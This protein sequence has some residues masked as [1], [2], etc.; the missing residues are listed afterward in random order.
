MPH[1]LNIDVKLK[2]LWQ[3]SKKMEKLDFLDTSEWIPVHTLPGFESC[4]EYFVNR[5]GEVLS[6]KG[7]KE[8]KLKLTVA[9]NGYYQVSLT[10]RLGQKG[11]IKC[12][13][14]KLVAFAFLDTPPTPYGNTK[15]CSLIDH[16]DENK[17]NNNVSN[18]RWVSRSENNNKRPYKRWFGTANPGCKDYKEKNK[19]YN[20]EYQRKRRKDPEFLKKERDYMRCKRAEKK[21]LKIEKSDN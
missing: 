2:V 1:E 6:T 20:R 11:V 18:L 8:K 19:E 4:I 7:G 15:G 9:S 5:K 12:M 21:S 17:L 16:I 14:H 13:V 10:Q 3:F